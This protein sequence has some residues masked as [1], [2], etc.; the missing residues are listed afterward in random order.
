MRQQIVAITGATS[1][2]G[3]ATARRFAAQGARLILI[4]RRQERLDALAA[5]L[6]G[7]AHVVALDI[8]DRAATLTAFASLPEACAAVSVLVNGAGLAS[9]TN[10]VAKGDFSDWDRMIDTNINGLLNVTRAVLPGMIERERGHI[11]NIGSVA[12]TYP[13][14]GPI[15]G[16]SKAFVNFFSL[17]LRRELL[18]S[19]VRTTS[20]EPGRVDTEFT[21][22]RLRGDEE[23]AKALEADGPFLSADDVAQTIVMCSDLPEHVNV[24][25]LEVMSVNQST[26][27]FSYVK[28]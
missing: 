10:P 26:G 9:G 25:R 23:R 7:S 11:I 27:P 17:N 21:L 8:T 19:K 2:I 16:S 18:G 13:S 4:G 14:G 1:G 24:N 22:V 5:E 20:I 15:Y 28:M 3:A 12:G 6:G